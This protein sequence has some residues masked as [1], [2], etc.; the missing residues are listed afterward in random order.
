MH[1]YNFRF[2]IQIAKFSLQTVLMVAGHIT[3]E[4]YDHREYILIWNRSI[5]RVK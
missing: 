3:H 5:E 1:Y 2:V 4:F